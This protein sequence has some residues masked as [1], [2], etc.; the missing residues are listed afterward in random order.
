[1]LLNTSLKTSIKV[2]TSKLLI[3][4]KQC[5]Q[6]K[7][8]F[9]QKNNQWLEGVLRIRNEKMQRIHTDVPKKTIGRPKKSFTNQS[10]RTQAREVSQLILD[11][12]SEKLSLATQRSLIKEGKRTAA[13]VIKMAT[14]SSPKKI[15]KMKDANSCLPFTT[16]TADEA[17]ALIIDADLGKEQYQHIQMQAKQKG[18]NIYPPYNLVLEAKR[19]VYPPNLIIT[20]LTAK[21]PLQDLLNHT[22][23]RLV[24]V[25]AEVFERVSNITT[26]VDVFYKW[27]L[28][29]SGGHSIYK[30]NFSNNSEYTDSHIILCTIVPL[31]ISNQDTNGKT[32][33][34]KNLSP[35]STR[36][37]RPIS[38][39]LKK[40][41]TE[42]IKDE[43]EEI[44]KQIS[45][46]QPTIITT[47]DDRQLVFK[48]VPVCT[49]IDGKT[50]NVL[51][52]TL[53][54]QACNVCNVTSKNVNNLPMVLQLPCNVHTYKYGISVLH[55]YLRFY[56]LFLH[57]AYR[58][59][60]KMW[61][62]R[63]AD[64][65]ESIARRKS[66]I[67]KRF[68][69]GMGLVIDQPKQ[70]GGNSNDGNTA[71]KFFDHPQ[72]VSEIT[73]LD[74][75][76]IERCSVILCTLAS[77]H[78]IKQEIFKMYCLDTAELF[79]N[80]YGWYKMSPSVHKV[81]IHG[82]E[83]I[84]S[85]PL[86]VGQLTEDVLEASHKQYKM[87]RLFHSR[88]TSRINTN[89]DI[90]NM[91]LLSSDPV[92]SALRKKLVKKRKPFCQEVIDML[93]IPDFLK[94]IQLDRAD[95]VED[96]IAEDI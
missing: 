54:S 66:T 89:T 83:I 42:T 4:W 64:A 48:H 28:D 79:I 57:V 37:C 29:G 61:Q 6:V 73:G 92:I 55:A 47:S 11:H 44:Q 3:K 67:A 7:T 96:D 69:E 31:E 81:L 16:Y 25:Q 84:N 91:M 53:S 2:F 39:K 24:L 71:R 87:I 43:Y 20:D 26:H 22:I 10:K 1:M 80:L 74:S 76:L 72:K 18:A 60:L 65:K 12:S 50:C 93:D 17:L 58:L 5:K 15:Q 8:Y 27:G 34:W 49:M 52:D 62:A 32:I 38:F 51:T 14:N 77:G 95:D 90:I 40:E 21:I 86:P 9:Q 33:Y 63:G 35:S 88:K 56:E 36:Y 68:Y 13:T 75:K 82:H 23:S 19:K 94:G 46:L 30:Q 78:Y 41:T 59:E 45:L 70:G 85:L